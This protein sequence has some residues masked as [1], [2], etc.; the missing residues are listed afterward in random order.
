MRDISCACSNF[1]D[2]FDID[3]FISFLSNDVKILKELPN[4]P[5]VT[6]M[7]VPRKCN[8]RCYEKRVLPVIMKR[9]VSF[10]YISLI[11]YLNLFSLSEA[12]SCLIFFNY[13]FLFLKIITLLKIINV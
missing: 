13:L 1:E 9:H 2:I 11:Y 10:Q 3:W 4:G 6:T 5:K 12:C 8:E 7:R